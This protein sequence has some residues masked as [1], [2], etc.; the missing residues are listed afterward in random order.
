MFALRGQR[1]ERAGAAD[2][3]SISSPTCSRPHPAF[4]EA[5][6]RQERAQTSQQAARRHIPAA[7]GATGNG[8]GREFTGEYTWETALCL[9]GGGNRALSGAYGVMRGLHKRDAL[10]KFGAIAGVSGLF[11]G[12]C[13]GSDLRDEGPRFCV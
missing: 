2:V 10:T 5:R 11:S 4:V 1:P 12:R 13:V 8:P 7:A 9:N 6:R 3:M